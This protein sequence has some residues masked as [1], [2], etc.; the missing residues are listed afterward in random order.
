MSNI[1]IICGK[2]HCGKT[3]FVK[4]TISQGKRKTFVFDCRNEYTNDENIVA[5]KNSDIKNF[6]DSVSKLKGCNIIIE[7]A[8]V[9][10]N[11]RGFSEKL[12]NM[13]VAK[14]HNRQQIFLIFHSLRSIP[15]YLFDMVDFL[16][17]FKTK[18]KAT[19]LETKYK[20]DFDIKNLYNKCRANPNPYHFEVLKF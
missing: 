3:T 2:Q 9:F 20:L 16:V 13:L 4:K 15:A 6:L 14:V 8:T 10:L 11:N 1:F 7:E 12:L 18:D 19:L 5:F 17:L